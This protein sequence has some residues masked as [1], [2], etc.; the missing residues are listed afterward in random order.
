MQASPPSPRGVSADVPAP[1]PL[2]PLPHILVADDD[3]FIRQIS[4]TMLS[5]SGY[6]VDEAEDGA[7]AW[8]AL[9]NDCYDLL[10]TDNN[11][12]KV[13]GI[14]LLK[15]LRA[16]R[17]EMP[18]IMATGTPP[19][20]ELTRQPWLQPTAVLVK[21]Y[22]FPEF[23]QTVK[24]VLGE[25][26]V[27][28]HAP[29]P[30]PEKA[31]QRIL[32]V[33]EDHDLGR[34]YAETLARL[35]CHVDVVADGAAAWAALRAN[36]YDLLIAEHELPTLTG[37]EL[38]KK[39]RAARM[40]VPVVL[41]AARLPAYELARNPA[42]QLAATLNKPFAVEALLDTVKHVLRAT[43]HPPGPAAPRPN[44]QTQ[45]LAAGWHL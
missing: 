26:E 13:T 32:V 8:A 12:P 31:P 3:T 27:I 38:V 30:R 9:N 4:S 18:V 11:M 37:V 24:T 14:E 17:M 15:M 10:I 39:L 22:T 29:E 34:L 6:E 7:A 19:T 40:A 44:A 35:D 25:T 20:R 21:P 33:D 36:K 2:L 45:P 16:A 5:R 23:L 41:A 28:A 1:G 43:D 42:L